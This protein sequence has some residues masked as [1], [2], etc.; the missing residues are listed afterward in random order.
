MKYSKSIFSV[1]ISVIFGSMLLLYGLFDSDNMLTFFIAVVLGYILLISSITLTY[2]IYILNSSIDQ[3]DNKL[4]KTTKIE[5]KQPELKKHS[6][7]FLREE[8]ET[9]RCFRLNMNSMGESRVNI[10]LAVSGGLFGL[11]VLKLS[12]IFQEEL[13][14][15]I[16]PLITGVVLT[17]LLLLGLITFGRT[18]ERDINIKIYTR[19]L[20]RIRRYFV[21]QDP[22]LKKYLILPINDDQPEFNILGSLNTKIGQL[23]SLESMVVIINSTLATVAVL[24]LKSKIPYLERVQSVKIAII[25]FLGVCILQYLYMYIR[26]DKADKEN[27]KNI[28]FPSE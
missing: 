21:Q 12:S 24:A 8:L 15:I 27:K 3:S 25:T 14:P 4:I 22:E 1:T 6:L 23:F 26:F 13:L 20:N 10:L 28:E 17:G 5:K 16:S 18:I 11:A 2:K 9:L 19:G 7:E